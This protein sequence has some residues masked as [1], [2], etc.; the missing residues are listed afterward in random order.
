MPTTRQAT[1]G[2]ST[3]FSLKRTASSET[4]DSMDAP[5]KSKKLKSGT[6]NSPLAS[7]NGD[8]Q[9]QSKDKEKRKKKRN[10]KKRKVSIVVSDPAP[11]RRARSSSTRVET[12]TPGIPTESPIVTPVE[13]GEPTLAPNSPPEPPSGPPDM[14]VDS[15]SDSEDE[16]SGPSTSTKNKGK[17]RE[18][19]RSMSPAVP[20]P[21]DATPQLPDAESALT[22]L[23][24]ASTSAQPSTSAQAENQAAEIAR[25]TQQLNEQNSLLQ[26]HQN[27]LNSV[28]QSLTCQICLDLL[29][30]PYALSPCGHISCYTCLLRWFTSDPG[31][32]MNGAVANP[33]DIVNGNA[34]N[35]PAAAGRH[36][37]GAA[38]AQRA[39][40]RRFIT[41]AK[42][43]PVCRASV[44]MRPVEVY[45]VKD[46]VASLV[47]SGLADYPAPSAPTTEG[48]NQDPWNNIF[49]PA[50]R[51]PG[52][53][54]LYGGFFG[55]PPAPPINEPRGNLEDMGFYD[56]QDGGIYRCLDC[57]HEIAGRRCSN[58]QCRRE[59]AGHDEDE[60][61]ESDDGYGYVQ[62]VLGGPVDIDLIDEDDEDGFYDGEYMYGNPELD[63]DEEPII[64][65]DGPQE[66][67][68]GSGEDDDDDDGPIEIASDDEDDD[69]EGLPLNARLTLQALGRQRR[70]GFPPL[71]EDESDDEDFHPH[72]V[73]RPP[74]GTRG[75]PIVLS[76]GEEG[77]ESDDDSFIVDDDEEEDGHAREEQEI[78]IE[79]DEEE[80]PAIRSRARGP[81]RAPSSDEEDEEEAQPM[82]YNLRVARNRIASPSEDEDE[83]SEPEIVDRRD[84][85]ARAAESRQRRSG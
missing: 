7:M 16:E 58:P 84:R 27:Q 5:R 57:M 13:A 74:R 8:S 35:L 61:D 53:A 47:R 39:S 45:A 66:A 9:G 56:A 2:S 10:K 31:Q 36:H 17:A 34:N 30:R 71:Q 21:L 23:I 11:A 3:G 55:M 43:C 69:D 33:E 77:E 51:R 19:V 46:M 14:V 18:V 65:N 38:F 54:G 50:N 67:L 82:R 44:P 26:R 6:S 49:P 28:Q 48:G 81:I 1:P 85:A 68:H 60:D 63:S 75:Q 40:L 72:L 70:L 62:H 64:F 59:Y 22:S 41:R 4:E 83:E 15:D 29:H 37:L 79:D 42:N 80:V 73:Q 52:M 24:M 76:A 78:N 12:R 20:P 25:L 32:P